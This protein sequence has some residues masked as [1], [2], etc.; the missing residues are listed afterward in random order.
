MGKYNEK[1]HTR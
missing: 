1:V